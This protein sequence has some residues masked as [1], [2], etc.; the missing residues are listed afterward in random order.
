MGKTSSKPHLQSFYSHL[1]GA[2]S[3]AEVN[4]NSSYFSAPLENVPLS[5]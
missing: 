4:R 2:A 1:E 3:Q 5:K